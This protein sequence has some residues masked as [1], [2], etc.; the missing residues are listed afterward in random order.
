MRKIFIKI[1]IPVVFCI[2][3]I[4]AAM[5]DLPPYKLAQVICSPENGF[6]SI[7]ALNLTDM[8][9]RSFDKSSLEKMGVYRGSVD[10]VCQIGQNAF[11]VHLEYSPRRGQ[12]LCGG[13]DTGYLTIYK[14]NKRVMDHVTFN[15]LCGNLTLTSVTYQGS[16]TDPSFGQVS[17]EG[18]VGF[19]G[20]GEYLGFFMEA[21]SF[22]NGVFDD[23]RIFEEEKA[24]HKLQAPLLRQLIG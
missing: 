2:T 15:R 18:Q 5:A 21:L 1:L 4:P 22:N 24:L 19:A 7:R 23:D 11:K 12:G 8:F 6:F 16:F 3:Q 9:S 14:N 13:D 17:L 10:K 20:N